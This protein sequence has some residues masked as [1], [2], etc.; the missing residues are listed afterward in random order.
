VVGVLVLVD[1]HVPEPAAVVLGHVREELEQRDR[2]HDQ[3]VEVHRPGL[4]K[5]PLVGRVRLGERLLQVGAGPVRRGLV[6]D[7]LVLH[8]AHLRGERARRVAL[9]VEVEL[10]ADQRHEPLGVGLVVDGEAAGEP[11][12]LRLPAQDAHTGA[13]EGHHPHR[14]RAR[15]DEPLDALLHLPGG[16][17][18]ERDRED[19]ARVHVTLGEQVGDAVGEHPRLAGP[20]TGDDEQRRALVEHG[21]ALLRVESVEEGRSVGSSGRHVP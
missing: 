9:G 15:A 11:Q 14:L 12:P 1:E 6:V 10:P 7:Q 17:V 4:G 18:G 20:G 13:V 2:E 19:L 3:V 5:P 21:L 8:R 16:L